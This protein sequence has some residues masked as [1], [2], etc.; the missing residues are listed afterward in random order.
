MAPLHRQ[1]WLYKEGF[2]RFATLKY[3]TDSSQLD[4]LY[5]H[6]TNSSIQK[7][8]GRS[9]L[10]PRLVGG[11]SSGRLYGGSKCSLTHMWDLL[12]VRPLGT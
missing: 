7:G 1:A 5:V 12:Q 6:L 9:E 4:N 10:P 8:Q 2:A 11:G 3:T